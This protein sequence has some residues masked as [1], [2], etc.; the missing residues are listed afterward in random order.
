VAKSC[1]IPRRKI[2]AR[3]RLRKAVRQTG[4]RLKFL[5]DFLS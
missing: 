5:T 2:G 4:Q 3:L 1:I